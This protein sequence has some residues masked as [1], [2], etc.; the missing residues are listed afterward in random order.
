MTITDEKVVLTG[1]RRSELRVGILCI[2][3]D[4]DSR[5]GLEAMVAQVP[6]AYVVGNVDRHI[7]AREAMRMLEPFQQRVSVID[8]D[9]N[10]EDNGR[11]AQRLCDGCDNSMT[12]FAAS[13]DPNPENIIAAMRCGCSEYLAVSY[14]H[15]TLP[16]I[17]L[18]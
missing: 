5:D 8:F 7:T 10:A 16:T 1:S 14:T 17:L 2:N 6:G 3:I 13:S 15:L 12:V 18:V 4:A 9:G 11:V